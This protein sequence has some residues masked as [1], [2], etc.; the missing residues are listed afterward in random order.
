MEDFGSPWG[1]SWGSPWGFHRRFLV[2]CCCSLLVDHRQFLLVIHFHLMFSLARPLLSL[3]L[4]S[5][6]SFTFS[7]SSFAWRS[8]SSFV[9]ARAAWRSAPVLPEQMPEVQDLR[10]PTSRL[11]RP[12]TSNPCLQ[13][14]VK[15]EIITKWVIHKNKIH[16]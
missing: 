4:I 13:I 3:S 8:A 9:C 6:W 2:A 1:S 10:H 16:I 5:A 12:V 15:H 14:N 7:N 11:T